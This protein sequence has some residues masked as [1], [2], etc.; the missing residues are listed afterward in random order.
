MT[1]GWTL[2]DVVL[3]LAAPHRRGG[4]RGAGAADA[5][6][7][8]AMSPRSVVV[9]LTTTDWRAALLAGQQ[10]KEIGCGLLRSQKHTACITERV[11]DWL[12]ELLKL[13]RKRSGCA[14]A[15]LGW[16]CPEPVGRSAF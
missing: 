10:L 2:R 12:V 16:R 7:G 13:C 3:P 11:A 9:A 5:L 1:D 4:A 6:I 15:C 8:D 14:S